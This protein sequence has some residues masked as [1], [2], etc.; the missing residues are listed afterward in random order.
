MTYARS[1]IYPRLKGL[2]LA[3]AFT[4]A[5]TQTHSHAHTHMHAHMHTHMHTHTHTHVHTDGKT[6]FR[7]KIVMTYCDGLKPTP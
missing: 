7:H 5:H 6:L 4:Q 3:P 1:I 2:Q